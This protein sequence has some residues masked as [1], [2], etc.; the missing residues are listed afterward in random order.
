MRQKIPL[1]HLMKDKIEVFWFESFCPAFPNSMRML[2]F[3][4]ERL[5][6]EKSFSRSI[7][8]SLNPFET[9]SSRCIIFKN[10]AEENGKGQ[11]EP[12]CLH[13]WA[14]SSVVRFIKNA[15]GDSTHLKRRFPT[16]FVLNFSIKGKRG[17][18]NLIFICDDEAEKIILIL[19]YVV[20]IKILPKAVS[21][22]Y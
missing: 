17:E 1:I 20:R 5:S 9:D 3:I 7:L 2:I 8:Q 22:K 12:D 6:V 11:I 13:L 14:E 21:R 10:A 18:K 15:E 4:S 16:C 19:V